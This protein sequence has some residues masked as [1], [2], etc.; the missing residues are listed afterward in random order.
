MGQNFAG[1]CACGAIRYETTADPTEM[2]NCHC[3][4][5][6]RA[7]GSAYAPVLIFETKAVKLSGEPRYYKTVGRAGKTVER[8]FCAYC[9]SQ[10][11]LKLE[12]HPNLIGFQAASLDDPSLYRPGMDIFTASAWYWD[13][14]QPATEK[15]VYG[16][17]D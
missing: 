14:M 1:G 13:H 5:C 2:V 10:V 7:G 16:F 15:R 3:R 12:R 9:G 11:T 6:Q 17:A 8:G 4:D